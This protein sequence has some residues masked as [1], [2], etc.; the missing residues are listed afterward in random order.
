MFARRRGIAWRRESSR[1]ERPLMLEL[2]GGYWAAY[3]IIYSQVDD[4]P[5]D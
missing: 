2:C 3:C 1:L 4:R 5:R